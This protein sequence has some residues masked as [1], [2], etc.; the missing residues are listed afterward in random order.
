MEASFS[1]WGPFAFPGSQTSP[2]RGAPSRSELLVIDEGMPVGEQTREFLGGFGTH[3]ED[4]AAAQAVPGPEQL[5][6]GQVAHQPIATRPTSI[7]P[8]LGSDVL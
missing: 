3:L 8:P 4:R 5:T 7:G 2:H 6:I 1:A